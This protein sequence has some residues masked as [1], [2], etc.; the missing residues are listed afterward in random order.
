MTT[1]A[2]PT[3]TCPKCKAE[4]PLTESLAA[5]LIEATRKQYER[6]LSQ[7]DREIEQREEA[8]REKEK[9]VA[10]AKRKLDQ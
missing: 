9:K 5:P 8:L 1:M 6:K 2:E 4:I 3:I 7:K 10:D